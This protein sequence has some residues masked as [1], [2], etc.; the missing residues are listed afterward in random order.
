MSA[1]VEKQD[2]TCEIP[3]P[4]LRLPPRP[5]V[6]HE[7]MMSKTATIPLTIAV[8]IEPMPLTMA[9]RQ[10]PM[11]WNTDLIYKER[12][13][14]LVV[15]VQSEVLEGATRLVLGLGRCLRTVLRDGR[16]Q[17]QQGPPYGLLLG[18]GERTMSAIV[19]SWNW[20]I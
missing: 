13:S 12:K 16:Q 14:Q 1:E 6:R 20:W 10:A 7:M 3:P 15:P 19:D 11:V 9:I 5:Q 2:Q 17:Q 18:E 8:R 4:R